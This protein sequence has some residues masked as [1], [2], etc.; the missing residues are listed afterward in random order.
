M[1]SRQQTLTPRFAGLIQRLHGW[2]GTGS[3]APD[4]APEISHAVI[5]GNDR[6]ENYHHAQE[7]FFSSGDLTRVAVAARNSWV[8]IRN[9][10]GSGLLVVVTDIVNRTPAQSV[11]G[12]FTQLQSANGVSTQTTSFYRDSRRGFGG[13]CPVVALTGDTA[14]LQGNGPLE[15]N[16]APAAGVQPLFSPP[17]ILTPGFDLLL[18]AIGQNLLVSGS[19]HGYARPL[20]PSDLQP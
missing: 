19:F 13:N 12:V 15:N 9:P 3:P 4:I 17:F 8:G 14:V 2:K 10:T 1:G 18:E 20:E 16:A 11:V 5:I 6:P 7:F